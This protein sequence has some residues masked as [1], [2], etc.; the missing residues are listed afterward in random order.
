MTAVVLLSHGSRDPRADVVTR[1]IASALSAALP[2][3]EVCVAYLDLAHPTLQQAVAAIPAT[4]GE[5]VVVP[6]LLSRA[7]HARV[8][9]PRLV[10]ALDREVVLAEPLGPALE[11]ALDGA[12]RLPAGPLVLAA[13]GTRDASAQLALQQLARALAVRLRQPVTV[14][15]AAQAHP[16]VADAIAETGAVGVIA[17][18][19]QPGI[20]PDRI[21]AAAAAA[22]IPATPPLGALQAVIDL[23][24]ERVYAPLA[25]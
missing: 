9:V 16:R 17:F 15:Y 18:V 21:A 7:F 1:E 19:L 24:R 25:S 6:M 10:R 13:A 22:G 4:A 3:V 5:I 2:G 12:A 11:L 14:G 20:L 23:L 8:D